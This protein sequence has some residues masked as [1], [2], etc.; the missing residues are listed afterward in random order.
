MK[1]R[2]IV[3]KIISE[4]FASKAQ[5]R[6]FYAMA[7][8]DT[9]KGKKFKKWAKEFSDD[10]DFDK[11]PEKVSKKKKRKTKK[12]SLNPKMKKGELVEYINSKKSINE[13]ARNRNEHR[14]PYIIREMDRMDVA[15][16]IRFLEKLRES[17][18]I[19]M[20]GASP[21][22]NWTRDDLK[23]WLYGQKQDPEYIE[24]QIEELEYE[25][26]DGDNDSDIEMLE[27]QLETINYLLDNKQ[28]VRD[29]LIRASLRRIDNTD[30][31]HEL[32]NVQRV[33]N[34]M[35]KEAWRM[36]TEAIYGQY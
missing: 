36:W 33:F 6:F 12:E 18:V 34:K 1:K 21:I 23:R 3:K 28:E 9:K 7:D 22:L 15:S 13:M 31:N 5:Q 29:A 27:S 8:K 4:K 26:E 2:D 32:N 14:G 24:S 35:S 20:F 19:N 25:N 30:G 10:T 17:G 16:V 11:L